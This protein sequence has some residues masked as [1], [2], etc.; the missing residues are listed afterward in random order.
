MSVSNEIVVKAV[1]KA[2]E[3]KMKK[4][5]I[6]KELTSCEKQIKEH[7]GIDVDILPKDTN[8]KQRLLSYKD[9]VS[10]SRTLELPNKVITSI[11]FI[12]GTETKVALNECS[13]KD[14][15][16]KAVMWCLLKKCFASKRGLEKIIYAL[17]DVA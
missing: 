8:P 1:E 2:V 12:D 11:K 7:L 5:Y 13:D 17:E 16:E 9:I 14:D 4:D 10:I 15:A 3:N 6:K